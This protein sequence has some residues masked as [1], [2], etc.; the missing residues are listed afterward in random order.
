M[1]ER[2]VGER[3]VIERLVMACLA[4]LCLT[5][6]LTAAGCASQSR[7]HD[8]EL[9]HFDEWLPGRYDDRA[10]IAA[11]SKAGRPT[12]EPV[13][14]S[15]VPVEAL[16]MGHHVFYVEESA[17]RIEPLGTP[18]LILAQHL[19]SI[20]TSNG[21]IVAALYSFTDPQ[22]WREGV[23]MPDI[24]SSLQPQD[25]KLMRGC[26]L[27]WAAE[28]QKLTG[29]DDPSHCLSESTLTG[30]VEPLAIHVE[31]TRDEIA[32]ST[33]PAAAGGSNPAAD[34]YTRFRRSGGP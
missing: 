31:V 19:V 13:A 16:Q 5:G 8:A 30:G 23:S 1:G 32:V 22:R 2:V 9:T 26:E 10:Q 28:P 11:A 34:S 20:D 12:P 21:K 3:L 15:V 27:T 29:A 6:A 17:G 25:V 18:H 14:L 33:E 7:Q 4:A 24:F